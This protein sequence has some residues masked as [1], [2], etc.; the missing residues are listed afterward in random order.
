MADLNSGRL[1]APPVHK[2][3][4]RPEAKSFDFPQATK[5][6]GGFK[7]ANPLIWG[8]WGGLVFAIGGT[9]ASFAGQL[10]PSQTIFGFGMGGLFWLSVCAEIWN[11][12]G[13][14]KP[15]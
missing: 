7:P 15:Q 2:A 11:R 12:L 13:S 9:I 10:S 8:A 14:R 1:P 3:L 5:P 6:E 4:P